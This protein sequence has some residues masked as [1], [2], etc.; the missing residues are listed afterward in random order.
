MYAVC[1]T[2]QASLLTLALFDGLILNKE[3]LHP[4][5]RTSNN[6]IRTCAWFY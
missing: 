4:G 2:L 3:R 5:Q 6:V 1:G